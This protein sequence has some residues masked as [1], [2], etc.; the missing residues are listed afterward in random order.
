MSDTHHRQSPYALCVY[1]CQ[2]YALILFQL[3]SL[4]LRKKVK[5]VVLPGKLT[6]DDPGEGTFGLVEMT[7]GYADDPGNKDGKLKSFIPM[8]VLYGGN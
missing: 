7:C 6:P 3:N 8:I 5:Y 2:R 4:F 1:V